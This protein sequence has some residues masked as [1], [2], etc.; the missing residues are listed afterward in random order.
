MPVGVLYLFE[1][2]VYLEEG[3]FVLG[4]KGLGGGSDWGAR[5]CG[6]VN[7]IIN[8]EILIEI[9]GVL[10]LEQFEFN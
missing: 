4:E 8:G 3:L 7:I 1:C 6:I 2:D 5:L 10:G 9:K